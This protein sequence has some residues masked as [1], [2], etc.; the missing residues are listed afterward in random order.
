MDIA[1]IGNMRRLL[2]KT[3]LRRKTKYMRKA[4]QACLVIAVLAT[5]VNAMDIT[6]RGDYLEARTSDVYTGPCFANG[7]MNLVGKE[8]ILTWHV[9]EGAWEG[10]PLAGLS[11]MAVLKAGNTLGYE[12][13][14]DP[15]S[16]LIVDAAANPEQRRA[17]AAFARDMAGEL[18]DDIVAVQV[19][20]I[21]FET[22]GHGEALAAAGS[23]AA[24]ETRC[25]SESDHICGNEDVFYPPLSKVSGATPAYTVVH[26]FS[27]QGLNSSWS[28]PYK[29]S[30][31]V[32]EFAR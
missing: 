23:I 3:I 31:F 24:L 30:A 5:S 28:S 17:L 10:V 1:T 22:G 26:Q 8:A 19:E 14:P 15:R 7:E 11:V 25:L 4:L 2:N 6:I 13:H 12:A 27:G 29:R 32:G 18:L 21:A 20:E 9:R 16:V